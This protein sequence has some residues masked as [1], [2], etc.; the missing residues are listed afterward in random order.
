MARRRLPPLNALRAF[1]AAARLGSFKAAADESFVT[2]GAI[3][4]HIQLLEKWLGTALFER[5]NRRVVLTDSGAAYLSEI[6]DALDHIAAATDLCR[7]QRGRRRLKVNANATF[8]VR[9]LLPRLAEFHDNH[10]D[11]EIEVITANDPVESID[12]SFD[13]VIRT[14][15][16][17]FDGYTTRPFLKDYRLPVCSPG[18]LTRIPLRQPEDLQDHTLLHCATRPR[19]W[20]QWLE[21]AGVPE[22]KPAKSITLDHYYLA[23]EGSLGGLGV[24]MGPVS[25]V[26]R[27]LATGRLVMPFPE[28][29][30]PARSYCTYVRSRLSN[31]TA[32]RSFGEWLATEG[33]A[34]GL[35]GPPQIST[36]ATLSE[37]V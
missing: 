3:S 19:F 12:E 18:L 22:L 4:R 1:E 21:A 10:P 6:G 32:V 11:I 23:L 14:G 7:S 20:N 35:L 30:V 28:L 9:W 13:V 33:G 8:T 16:D 17:T 34:S 15:P 24:A 27:D 26:A 36:L 25:F 31:E 2:H 29:S 5:R 37:Q